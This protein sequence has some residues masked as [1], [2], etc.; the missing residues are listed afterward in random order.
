MKSISFYSNSNDVLR[1]RRDAFLFI[2]LL[3][4]FLNFIF[5]FLEVIGFYLFLLINIFLIVMFYDTYF[6]HPINWKLHFYLNE[7]MIRAGFFSYKWSYFKCF[8]VIHE[9]EKCIILLKGFLFD[10]AFPIVVPVKK[11]ICK[12]VLELVKSKLPEEKSTLIKR[13]EE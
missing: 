8:E 5:L 13:K 9:K 12:K 3:I 4:I 10:Y 2:L 1:Y 6:R 7:S 11:S